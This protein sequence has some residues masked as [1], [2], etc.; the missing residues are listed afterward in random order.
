[1]ETLEDKLVILSEIKS[2]IPFLKEL[3]FEDLKLIV[4]DMALKKYNKNEVILEQ[5]STG[6]EICIIYS[7]RCQVS[8]GQVHSKD[9]RERMKFVE[10]GVLEKG[11]YFGE[12]AVVSGRKRSA[13]V[14]AK[15]K[16]TWIIELKLKFDNPKKDSKL[17]LILVKIYKTFLVDVAVKLLDVNKK[18]HDVSLHRFI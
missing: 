11:D 16:D 18:V 15:D 1:M 8:Y 17:D 7:G 12:L 9:P 14:T 5:E 2:T 10:V 3:T 13:Q 4:E 6:N